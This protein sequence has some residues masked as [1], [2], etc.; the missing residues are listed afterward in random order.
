[1]ELN[2]K[3]FTNGDL[4]KDFILTLQSADLF[5]E[6]INTKIEARIKEVITAG[7]PY[8]FIPNGFISDTFQVNMGYG[9]I[10]LTLEG[11]TTQYIFLHPKVEEVQMMM[12]A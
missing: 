7:Q 3:K 8:E 11:E 4:T 10:E 12:A 6:I 5:A 9:R 1:M 2:I